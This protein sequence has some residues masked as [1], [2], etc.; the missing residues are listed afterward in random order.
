L[1]LENRTG[2]VIYM[3]NISDQQATPLPESLP[4]IEPT[5]QPTL[6]EASPLPKPKKWLFIIFGVTLTF[7][8]GVIG[9]L[10]YQNYQ[11]KRVLETKPSPSPIPSLSP[12]PQAEEEIK[13]IDGNIYRTGLSGK[14]ELLV[15]KEDPQF[16]TDSIQEFSNVNTS[17][18]KSK[19][20]FIGLPPAPAPSLYYKNLDTNEVLKIGW[21]KNCFWSPD[22]QKI[23][24]N[25]NTTDVSPVDI[26]V[27]D[28]LSEE[29]KNLTEN[30]SQEGIMRVYDFP[31]W[32]D[33]TTIVSTFVE[34]LEETRIERES[35]INI[36]TGEII[37]K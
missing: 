37:D 28:L 16:K 10:V 31:R 11:T 30:T 34:P 5:P 26:F 17:P 19:I 12:T 33:N 25:N 2:K 20:C 21:G 23:A 6:P 29:I 22:S 3:D 32:K 14:T 7:L 15:N 18:D 24:Y 13:I 9:F 36:L 27:Y 35:T 4:I 8:I 1:H